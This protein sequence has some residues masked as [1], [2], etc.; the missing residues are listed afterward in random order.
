VLRKELTAEADTLQQ[1]LV[2][3]SLQRT[4]KGRVLL[5]DEAG[6]VSVRGN[7]RPLPARRSP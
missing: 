1:L 6:L 2:N 3:E 7:A 4:M 5:V